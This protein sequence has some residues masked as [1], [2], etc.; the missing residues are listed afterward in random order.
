[1]TRYV[2]YSEENA[3]MESVMIR[4]RKILAT[5]G[6]G[7]VR[8]FEVLE[9]KFLRSGMEID[10]HTKRKR[11]RVQILFCAS[12]LDVYGLDVRQTDLVYR[13]ELVK[14]NHDRSKK[15]R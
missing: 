5:I 11:Y 10:L 14:E 1:M 6:S 4:P 2:R 8:E 3:W 13:T 9:K 12:K 7:P 15:V